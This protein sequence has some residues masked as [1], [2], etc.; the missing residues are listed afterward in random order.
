MGY[1]MLASAATILLSLAVVAQDWN[2]FENFL[3]KWVREDDSAQGEIWWMT[4]HGLRGF[5][6]QIDSVTKDTAHTENLWIIYNEGT[7]YYVAEVAHNP[8]PVLFPLIESTET[9]FLFENPKHDFPKRIEYWFDGGA[10]IVKLTGDENQF[11]L[12]IHLRRRE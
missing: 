12:W 10:V 7:Y 3:G 9:R 6:F 11:R 1:R 2:T 4:E 5:G 8:Q